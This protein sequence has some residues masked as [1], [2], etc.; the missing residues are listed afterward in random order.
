[1][2]NGRYVEEGEQSFSNMGEDVTKFS[3]EDAKHNYW[4]HMINNLPT[5]WVEEFKAPFQQTKS[6]E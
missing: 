4:L 2:D 6:K 3:M 5:T 1:L